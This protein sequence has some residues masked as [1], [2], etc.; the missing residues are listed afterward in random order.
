MI[1]E[2]ILIT[3]FILAFLSIILEEVLKVN[4][5]KTTLF[6]GTLSW[7]I[8]FLSSISHG[9]FEHINESFNE[10]ILE[11]STLWLFL[12]AAM[13]F[14]A[15][16]NKKGFIQ[17][18]T[19]RFL[20]KKI[21]ESQLLYLVGG[22]TFIF[23]S[24]SDN[25]TATMISLTLV[26]SLNLETKKLL[27]FAVLIIFAV[28]S[29]GAAL[30]TGDVTTLMI[31]TA[32]KVL[33]QD[34]LFLVLPSFLSVMFLAFLLSF[35]M[36]KKLEIKNDKFD[37]I[38][39]IDIIIASVFFS[40]IGAIIFGSILFKI[41]PLLTFLFGLSVM[42]LIGWVYEYTTKG[43]LKL[44][45]YIREIEFDA[46]LFFLGVLL[47]VGM[48]KEIGVLSLLTQIYNIFPNT[49]ANYVLGLFSSIVDNIPL[50]AAVLKSGV[51]LSSKEWLTLTY[52]LGVGGSLLII[53]SA[54]GIIAMSKIK[55]LTFLNY[56][57]YTPHILLAYSFGFIGS[58]IVAMCVI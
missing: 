52:S 40:T 34:L 6:F 55:E 3:I 41:P 25:I 13:T 32:D 24:L 37:K 9:G 42:F 21:S 44:L 45:D 43:D 30:I 16:L 17:T 50:T 26:M 10:N 51:T 4:K 56:L 18:L 31:Y 46:L 19:Y 8:L 49:I 39:K 5:A 11:I 27:K 15:Y 57:K 54:S 35:G 53:G 20:P 47:L 12:M 14:V 33:M 58:V 23:S 48:L 29:G 28:N 38:R 1:I 36:N 2:I 7:L 22:L